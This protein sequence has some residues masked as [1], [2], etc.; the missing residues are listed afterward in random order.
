MRFAQHSTKNRDW[1]KD[2][3]KAVR[4]YCLSSKGKIDIKPLKKETQYE[5]GNAPLGVAFLALLVLAAH[6]MGDDGEGEIGVNAFFAHLNSLLDV[7]ANGRGKLKGEDELWEIWNKW[8]KKRGY[9]PTA[10]AGVGPQKYIGYAIS[11]ALLRESDR[12]RLWKIFHERSYPLD[13]DEQLLITKLL[14]HR[15]Y[16]TRHLQELLDQEGL[17]WQKA[18]Q[19]IVEACFEVYED[20]RESDVKEE[21]GYKSQE[22]RHSLNARIYRA[23]DIFE[24]VPVYHLIAKRPRKVEVDELLVQFEGQDYEFSSRQGWFENFELS[25]NAEHLAKGLE[26]KIVSHPSLKK[27]ILPKRKFWVLTPEPD[28]PEDGSYADWGQGVEFGVS[29]ILLVHR[30]LQGEVEKLQQ[31]E[32]LTYKSC[33]PVFGDNSWF[34]YRDV[35]II[36][37]FSVPQDDSDARALREALLPRSKMNISFVEGIRAARGATWL[38]DYPPKIVLLGFDR[39]MELEVSDEYER[40]IFSK[41]VEPAEPIEITWNGEGTYFIKLIGVGRKGTREKS[42]Q[43]VGWHDLEVSSA[44]EKHLKEIISKETSYYI[45]AWYGG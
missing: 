37:E 27:L 45:G 14:R 13:L 15:Q 41:I 24:N 3:L 35:R 40:T 21:E 44:E 33:I 18:N 29:F 8:L 10:A 6:K 17:L 31:E 32:N 38:V 28:F 4:Q 11:Q 16:L 42:I 25:I 39:Q 1:Y 9:V 2:Y 5:R 12:H 23:Y 26:L 34:E 30:S 36:S 19:S 7:D 43:L 20:W 22:A